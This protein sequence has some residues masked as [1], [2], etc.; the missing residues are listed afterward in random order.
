MKRGVCLALVD[1]LELLSAADWNI[2]VFQPKCR[3]RTEA[4][5]TNQ[6]KKNAVREITDTGQI[7]SHHDRQRLEA[8]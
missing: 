3:I 8:S 7:N 2:L 4:A 1:T 6:T 5:S